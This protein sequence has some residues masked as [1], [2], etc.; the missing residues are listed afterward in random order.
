MNLAR[1]FVFPRIGLQNSGMK[2]CT[3]QERAKFHNK[4]GKIP[5]AVLQ[6]TFFAKLTYFNFLHLLNSNWLRCF[7][8]LSESRIFS[9][10]K[11]T[12]VLILKFVRAV[13]VECAI[14]TFHNLTN[15]SH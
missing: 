9:N 8:I 4:L 15:K 10:K 7:H 1:N 11:Q 6:R 12:K 13:S 5:S 3:T 14:I 2:P